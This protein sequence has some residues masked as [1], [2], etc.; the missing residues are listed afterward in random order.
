M[1]H[2]SPSANLLTVIGY[3]SRILF[4]MICSNMLQDIDVGNITDRLEIKKR[5]K[6]KS[7]EWYL[8]NIW[9]ELLRFEDN[10]RASGQVNAQLYTRILTDQFTT[11]CTFI[12]YLEFAVYSGVSRIYY[13]LNY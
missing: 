7:F 10:V 5:L 11:Y 13:K 8:E 12:S 4:K 9:P 6:C 2:T 3:I 1:P